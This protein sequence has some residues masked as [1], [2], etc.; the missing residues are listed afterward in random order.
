M[1]RCGSSP[2]ITS[3]RPASPPRGPPGRTGGPGGTSRLPALA[4]CHFDSPP[5]V[6]IT[7]QVNR[8]ERKLDRPIRQLGFQET[9]VAAMA[10]P[11]AKAAWRGESIE[12]V[13]TRV[14]E[15]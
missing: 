6:F 5:A 10:A 2:A 12:G 4:R 3:R 7:G 13:P 8:H 14:A 1:A 15:A 9:D 11:I